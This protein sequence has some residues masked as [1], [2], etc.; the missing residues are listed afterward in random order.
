MFSKPNFIRGW[1]SAATVFTCLWT[2]RD[3][4]EHFF[5]GSLIPWFIGIALAGA[6]IWSAQPF[7]KKVCSTEK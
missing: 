5:N 3:I 2:G 4:G 7:F 6:I 1:Y